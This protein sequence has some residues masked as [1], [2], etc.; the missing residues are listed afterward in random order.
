M[1]LEVGMLRESSRADV[2]LVGPGTAVH[3]HVGLEVTRCRERLGA[4]STFVRLFLKQKLNNISLSIL[5][6]LINSL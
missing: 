6:N 3:V 1:V 4:E 5:V 2:A